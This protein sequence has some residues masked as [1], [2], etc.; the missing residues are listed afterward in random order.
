MPNIAPIIMSYA[1]R[2]FHRMR[3]NSQQWYDT[4]LCCFSSRFW[5]L[6]SF[7][8]WWLSSFTTGDKLWNRNSLTIC[9]VPCEKI[10]N[11]KTNRLNDWKEMK[12]RARFKINDT[13]KHTNPQKMPKQSLQIPRTKN[14]K[15]SNKSTTLVSEPFK[16]S[17]RAFDN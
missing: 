10:N 17:V 4:F 2:W 3:C 9:H 8:V 13:I 14:K 16:N 11:A 12:F 7:V 5:L 15:W 6:F 1:K